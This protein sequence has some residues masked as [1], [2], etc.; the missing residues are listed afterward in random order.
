MLD[1]RDA[2]E[3][4]RPFGAERLWYEQHG[5]PSPRDGA[6]ADVREL[7][8][9]RGAEALVGLD[10]LWTVEPARVAVNAAPIA[11]LAS[12]PGM[13]TEAVARLAEQRLRGEPFVDLQRFAEGLSP[14][15]RDSIVARYPELVGRVTADPDAWIVTSTGRMGEVSAALEVVL[16]R[17]GARAAIVRRRT[18]S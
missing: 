9:V 11:V 2:D 7:A 17:A 4:P 13:T 6:F 14:A 16:V 12:L 8:R 15:A 3:L 5:R 1:W 10:S 18:W